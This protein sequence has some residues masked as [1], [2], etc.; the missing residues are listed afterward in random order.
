MEKSTVEI[1]IPPGI[2]QSVIYRVMEICGVNYQIKKDPVLDREYSVLSGYPEQ[3]EEAKKYLK[4]FTEAKL[5]LRDISRLA[6]RYKTLAKLYTE[7][8]ELRGIL[9]VAS[10]DIANREWI[11]VC[12]EKPLDGE[13]ETLE[14]CGKKVYVYV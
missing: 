3:I 9:S 13:Y 6:R 1:V 5:A 2:P 11:E 10:Q 14:I 12:K 7:D 8:E 4:L